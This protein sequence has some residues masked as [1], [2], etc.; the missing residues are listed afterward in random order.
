MLVS[1]A[2]QA[3]TLYDYQREYGET[4]INPDKLRILIDRLLLR[5]AAQ[6][7]DK[8][9]WPK[10]RI[11]QLTRKQLKRIKQSGRLS[12]MLNQNNMSLEEFKAKLHQDMTN[13]ALERQILDNYYPDKLRADTA[14]VGVVRARLIVVGDSKTANRIYKKLRN[15]AKNKRQHKWGELFNR[16][17]TRLSFTKKYG[18]LDWFQWGQYNSTIEY[19]LYKL[20]TFGISTPFS[21]NDRHGLVYKTGHRFK[22]DN[23]PSDKAIK[24][25]NRYQRRY[26]TN[27]LYKKL[28]E[29]YPII[30]ADSIKNTMGEK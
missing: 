14:D 3:I 26:Y 7:N 19:Q 16:Y 2:D 24:T 18:R 12:L 28:R 10:N 23:P 29:V 8:I 6:K 17:S 15:T 5:I 22:S 25:Y 21:I 4:T 20:P 9:T 1:V 11:N 30:Y 27:K 13:Q